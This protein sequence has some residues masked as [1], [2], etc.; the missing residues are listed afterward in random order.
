MKHLLSLLFLLCANTTFAQSETVEFPFDTIGFPKAFVEKPEPGACYAF[1]YQPDIYATPD[2]KRY[3]VFTKRKKYSNPILKCTKTDT[4]IQKL[5]LKWVQKPNIKLPKGVKL[6]DPVYKE[7][8]IFRET[9]PKSVRWIIKNGYANCM[10]TN[11]NFAQVFCLVEVPAQHL[12]EITAYKEQK[13]PRKIIKN[14]TIILTNTERFEYYKEVS[15]TKVCIFNTKYDI[16][17]RG[18]AFYKNTF[19]CAERLPKNA[20]LIE[21]GKI[22]EWEK[23]VCVSCTLKPAK[24]L[25]IQNAL[26]AKGYYKGPLDNIMNRK[27]KKALKQFQKDNSLPIGSLDS[28]TKK[29]L[30]VAD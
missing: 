16:I 23:V 11:T 19:Y 3:E 7:T 25:E 28:R 18:K 14:D 6:L 4:I 22:S 5:P 29:A 26:T 15:D 20:V 8:T 17:K 12:E 24:T 1:V 13:P 9:V 2:G 30:G 21:K 27:T 10:R